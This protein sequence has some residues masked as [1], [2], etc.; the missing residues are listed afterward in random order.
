MDIDHLQAALGI[1]QVAD[2]GGALRHFAVPD[3]L[4]RGGMAERVAAIIQGYEAIPFGCVE[5]FNFA[6]RRGLR[7]GFGAFVVVMSHMNRR[8]TQAG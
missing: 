6:R 5:P 8:H 7:E 2:D 3:R 4:Q 1:R